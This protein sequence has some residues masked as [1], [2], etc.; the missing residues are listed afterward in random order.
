MIRL[1]CVLSYLQ[2]S[3]CGGSER[4]LP[5]IQNFFSNFAGSNSGDDDNLQVPYEVVQKFEARTN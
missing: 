5:V 3:Y 1:F 2:F 4:T